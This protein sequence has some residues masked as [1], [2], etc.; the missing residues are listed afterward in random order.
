MVRG[1]DF[2]LKERCYEEIGV[3][4]LERESIKQYILAKVKSDDDYHAVADGAMDIR[5]I[6][7]KL[8]ILKKVVNDL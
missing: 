6:D 8:E 7:S 4:L 1:G 3:L 2:D 5:D